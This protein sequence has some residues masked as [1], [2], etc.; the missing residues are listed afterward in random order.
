M[1]AKWLRFQMWAVVAALC[2]FGLVM[3]ASTTGT[4]GVKDGGVTYG[5]IVKQAAAM[6]LGVVM[7]ILVSAIGVERWR[8][9]RLVSLAVLGTIAALA[10]VLAVGRSING[11]R[12]WIDLGPINLQPAELA[13]FALVVAAAW[14][15]GRA[16]EKVRS[17]F[18]GVLLP[19]AGFAVV[20][21][22]IYLTK[23]L[24]S[25]L[26]LG[27]VL[28]A[29][30]AYAG[31]PWLYFMAITLASAPALVY[32]TVFSEGYRRDR[33]LAFLDPEKYDGPAAYHLRQSFIAIGS[34]G[35]FG[36]GLGE[37]STKLGL[38][39]EKHTDFIYAVVCEEF[40]MVGAI[41]LAAAFLVLVVTGLLIAANTRE[42]HQRL[43]AIGATMALGI[44]AFWNMLV[45][46]GAVPTKG[47]TLPFI[48]YG[49]SSVLVCLALVGLLDAVAR[50][51]AERS[52]K[53]S[54][55]SVRIGARIRSEK[56]LQWRT[57]LNP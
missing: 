37:G 45:V 4:L 47:L 16:A 15:F 26:V 41:A 34:G 18:H 42:L 19:M 10:A 9:G 38:L 13:K 24:G 21:G 28:A 5:Y 23:D 48:S 56:A 17:Y 46:T 32:V 7:A 12:R 25:V 1:S 50:A 54:T 35:L 39:P 36:V 8:D 57:E 3:I 20:A 29:M 51:N 43:L 31:A 27:L 2:G 53:A 52:L 33:I 49:G 44:Q 55:T 11:A 30:L 22:L 40:G 6:G 14:H